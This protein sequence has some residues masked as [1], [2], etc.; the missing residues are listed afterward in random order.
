MTSFYSSASNFSGA[1]VGGVDPR[2]GLFNISL[3]LI[4]LLSGSLAGPPLSLALHYSPLSTINNGF[5][6]GFELN[7]SSYDTH[8]GKLLLSTGEEY[9]VSSSGKIVKQK[10]LNNFAFKKLD[11]ANCQ[12]VYKSGLIEHLSLHKSVFVPSR[13]SGPCG[14]SLNLRWSSK[15]T[16]ARLTQVSDGDGTVLCSMAYPDESYATTTFTVLPDDN[17]RSYDTIF[18][19]TNEHL[20]KVTCHMVEPALVWTFDYD[21]V[22]P[23][24]GCRAITTVAAP[25][26]LIEQVRYYSEEGMAFPD[27]AKLPALPCVQR[28]TVSPG[29]GQAKSVTQWTWTKNNYLG[30]NAGLNQWQPDTDGMLNILL[31]DYQYGSTADL[32]SSDGKT[33]LSS[34][35]RRYNSYHLQESEAMLKDGKKHTKTTQ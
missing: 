31:S 11:D 21:D 34:V 26:G 27:I 2:T 8:T 10:K 22:G 15:Y 18:K 33:V 19:F 12:I 13:I 7:L 30:N 23:K 1:E 24:K 28:H 9:R 4:K 14:R 25:T 32:M 3:P 35:T 6:I 17:E 20:V 29:G 16:P 5:G